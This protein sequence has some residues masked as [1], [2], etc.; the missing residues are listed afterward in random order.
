VAVVVSVTTAEEGDAAA[1]TETVAVEGRV[2]VA[3]ELAV[4]G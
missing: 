4:V 3:V 2:T 1:V